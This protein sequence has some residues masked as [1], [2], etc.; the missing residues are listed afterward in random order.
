MC[1]LPAVLILPPLSLRCNK[2]ASAC[3]SAWGRHTPFLFTASVV[4]VSV[5]WIFVVR[6]WSRQIQSIAADQRT[7][8]CSNVIGNRIIQ[9]CDLSLSLSLSLS[10]V[11][12]T[13]CHFFVDHF[14]ICKAYQWRITGASMVSGRHHSRCIV[15]TMVLSIIYTHNTLYQSS[16][17]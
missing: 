8:H 1:E 15:T 14:F 10:Q 11:C 4:S 2:L 3:A 7:Y 16:C 5:F 6:R 12:F 17:Y 13:L 9:V